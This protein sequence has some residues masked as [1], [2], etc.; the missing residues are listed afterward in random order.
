LIEI[1]PASVDPSESLKKFCL[2][3]ISLIKRQAISRSAWHRR[4]AVE[5]SGRG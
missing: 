5:K 2:R 3:G 4:H 1:K